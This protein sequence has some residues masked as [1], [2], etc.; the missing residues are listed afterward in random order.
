VGS[1]ALILGDVCLEAIVRLVWH[2]SSYSVV[3]FL[4]EC[5]GRECGQP[6]GLLVRRRMLLFL[7][8]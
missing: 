5:S 3:V 8:S 7:E 2:C 6:S 4:V 1:G